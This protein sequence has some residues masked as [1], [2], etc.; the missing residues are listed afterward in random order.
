MWLEN[1]NALDTLTDALRTAGRDDLAD[2]LDRDLGRR[3]QHRHRKVIH[4][5]LATVPLSGSVSAAVT[6]ATV[7]VGAFAG[8]GAVWLLLQDGIATRCT[9]WITLTGVPETT[10]TTSFEINWSATCAS[11]WPGKRYLMAEA[12]KVGADNTR[13][14]SE[15]L[16]KAAMS[17]ISKTGV[18]S[19]T[20]EGAC[21]S[22][23][24]L[25]VVS[26]TEAEEAELR[27]SVGTDKT[28]GSVTGNGTVY[29]GGSFPVT[30]ERFRVSQ[31]WSN[32]HL[33][34]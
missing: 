27:A 13:K 23:W 30:V 10:L 29:W 26:V 9:E 31:Y 2:D 3:I 17:S 24:R 7:L 1:R 22:E 6:V 4:R 16:F 25:F 20:I 28:K 18:V 19:T 34:A 15:F 32:T 21:G 12:L 33:C 5:R 8:G 14:H 11:P